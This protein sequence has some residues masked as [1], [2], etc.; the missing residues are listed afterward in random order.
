M[1]N[2]SFDSV[3]NCPPSVEAYRRL[4]RRRGPAT[5]GRLR[6]LLHVVLQ[7]GRCT[8]ESLASE[9]VSLAA[10]YL[11]TQRERDGTRGS[12]LVR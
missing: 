2:E 10:Q 9:E 4:S 3:M 8:L 1:S 5:G 11:D 7:L 6:N 12:S